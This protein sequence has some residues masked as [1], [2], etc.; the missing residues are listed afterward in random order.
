MFDF[1]DEQG[2]IA[3]CV[4]YNK[5]NNNWRNTK[6]PL[7]AWAIYEIYKVDKDIDFLKKVYPKLIKYHNWWYQYRDIDKNGLCEYGATDGT[8]IAARWESGMDNAVRYDSSKMVKKSDYAWSLNQESVDLNA[9]LYKEKLYLQKIAKALNK[10]YS[11]FITEAIELKNKIKLFFDKNLKYFYDKKIK[12]IDLVLD[13]G[14]EGWI[15][16]WAEAASANQ[17]IGVKD[18]ILKI[19][20]FNSKVPCPTLCIDHPKLNPLKGY[21]RGPVW[22]DQFYFAVKGLSNYGFKDESNFLINKFLKNADGLVNSDKPIRETYHPISGKG[23]NGR[24]FSW[25]AAHII[26]LLTE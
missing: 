8:W 20:K 19:N 24:H 18:M 10:E 26:L 7:S 12:S 16:L 1:Q 6:A 15:P 25:S 4:Y 21:W 13:E 5:K 2:M 22:V 3:D 9:Y 17:A 11:N 23:L 14:P